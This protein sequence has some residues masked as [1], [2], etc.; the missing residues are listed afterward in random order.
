MNDKS[1]TF[2]RDRVLAAWLPTSAFAT[3]ADRD[4]FVAFARAHVGQARTQ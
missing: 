2:G 4:A 3:P 1:I